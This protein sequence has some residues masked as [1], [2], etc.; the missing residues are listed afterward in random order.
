MATS[1]FGTPISYTPECPCGAPI[2]LRGP[3]GATCKAGH[4]ARLSLGPVAYLEWPLPGAWHYERPP[5]PESVWEAAVDDHRHCLACGRGVYFG[6]LLNGDEH[7]C[8]PDSV[9]KPRPSND[10]GIVLSDETLF[11][12]AKDTGITV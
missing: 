12:P 2:R 7:A 5:R 1:D 6:R 10:T 11:S 3:A 8:P 9:A 4:V